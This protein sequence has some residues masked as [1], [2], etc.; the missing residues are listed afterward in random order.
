MI[1]GYDHILDCEDDGKNIL[2][3][4]E[5]EGNTSTVE[6]LKSVEN[7]T[8]RNFLKP[9]LKIFTLKFKLGGQEFEKRYVA[10]YYFEGIEKSCSC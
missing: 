4:A 2:Q 5:E 1:E 9:I 6:F 7:Y 8:V 3:I 10:H